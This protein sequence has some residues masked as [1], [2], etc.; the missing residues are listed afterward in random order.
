M[1][2]RSQARHKQDRQPVEQA[3]IHIIFQEAFPEC[4]STATGPKPSP[5]KAADRPGESAQV[6][7][8]AQAGIWKVKVGQPFP[9]LRPPEMDPRSPCG[10]RDPYRS[11]LLPGLRLVKR[12]PHLIASDLTGGDN[13]TQLR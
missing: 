11:G 10:R 1:F 12:F 3:G 6:S 4:S 7:D 9:I 13:P 8:Y 5:G 2:R